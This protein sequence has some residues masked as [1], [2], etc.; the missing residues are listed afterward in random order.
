MKTGLHNFHPLPTSAPTAEQM[1]LIF[2]QFSDISSSQIIKRSRLAAS[3][4][5]EC[6]LQ[7]LEEVGDCP[8]DL[9]IWMIN[10]N[11]LE[12]LQHCQRCHGEVHLQRDSE[13]ADGVV[14]RC[15]RQD[16]RWNRSFRANSFFANSHL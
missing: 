8:I 16:C 10:E 2:F 15:A 11:Y 6:P 7:T 13:F 14:W 3:I 4:R 5:M 9:A 1:T 12:I